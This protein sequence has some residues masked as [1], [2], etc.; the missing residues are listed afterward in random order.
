M[1][2]RAGS[3]A[4]IIDQHCDW[5]GEGGYGVRDEDMSD[6]VN[7]QNCQYIMATGVELT[8]S[9]LTSET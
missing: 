5:G 9:N 8:S 1:L 2:C 3:P 4:V 6:T 7:F